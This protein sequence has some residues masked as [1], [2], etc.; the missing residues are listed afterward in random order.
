MVTNM[1]I[2]YRLVS[3]S[4]ET[5]LF[6]VDT[7]GQLSL[8]RTLDRELQD[9][10][11]VAILAETDSSPPLTALAEVTLKVLD[12]N[13]HAPEFESSPYRL[14]LA[15]NIEEGTSILKG[16]FCFSV[17]SVRMIVF[18]TLGVKGSQFET[19]ESNFVTFWIRDWISFRIGTSKLSDN[20]ALSI[21]V[22]TFTAERLIFSVLVPSALLSVI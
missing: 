18:L 12:E 7:Q 4:E 14:T 1:S 6:A 17:L 22:N 9:S 5:P 3:G 20:T 15:E 8:A 13:D 11:V 21:S 19:L 16:L 2:H 10:H